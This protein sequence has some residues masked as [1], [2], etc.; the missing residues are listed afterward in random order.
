MD[1]PRMEQHAD[2][3]FAVN[4]SRPGGLQVNRASSIMSAQTHASF[5]SAGEMLARAQQLADETI[6]SAQTGYQEACKQ[7]YQDGMEQARQ[8]ATHENI[9]LSL[10]RQAAL[11]SLE[12]DVSALVLQTL[13]Q[14]IGR[15]DHSE[16]VCMLVREALGRLG[17][18]QGE[19]AVHVHPDMVEHVAS[20]ILQWQASYHEASLKTIADPALDVNTCRVVCS[21]GRVEGNLQQQ[22]AAIESALSTQDAQGVQSGSDDGFA[23]DL[24]RIRAGFAPN[25]GCRM[26]E[27]KTC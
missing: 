7:G 13:R 1:I 25:A 26:P 21:S 9:V 3:R 4:H 5:L 6:A 8:Y 2:A 18:T 24:R 19:I 11:E 16:L 15:I 23:P 12:Q 17:K 20:G 27:H 14:M 22:L 10:S